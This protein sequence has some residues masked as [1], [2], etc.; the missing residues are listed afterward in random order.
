VKAGL[1]AG[2]WR[3]EGVT[4]LRF[5]AEVFNEKEMGL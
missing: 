2:S 1:P 3:S 4:I 5:T